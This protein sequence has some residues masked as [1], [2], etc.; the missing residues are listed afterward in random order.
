MARG[1]AALQ[2]GGWQRLGR[3]REEDDAEGGT[4]WA[5]SKNRSEDLMGY[6]GEVGRDGLG[7]KMEI[8]PEII[9]ASTEH[10]PN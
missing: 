2:S 5:Q 3:L 6:H 8:K 9:W 10:R 4:S 1:T 7:R